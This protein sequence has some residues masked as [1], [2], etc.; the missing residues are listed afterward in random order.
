M[1]YTHH[2]H[3][4]GTWVDLPC[5]TIQKFPTSPPTKPYLGLGVGDPE[6]GDIS[7]QELSDKS[8]LHVSPV[9]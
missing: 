5:D 8:Y 7:N 4:P 3:I 2:Q 9:H 6:G 1:V